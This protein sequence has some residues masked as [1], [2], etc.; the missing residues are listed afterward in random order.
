M[1]NVLEAREAFYWLGRSFMFMGIPLPGVPRKTFFNLI[2]MI[3]KF[4]YIY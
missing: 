2:Y 4:L 3:V 1:V